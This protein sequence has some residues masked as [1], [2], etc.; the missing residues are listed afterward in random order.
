MTA[1]P[2][3]ATTTRKRRP[4]PGC[5]VRA[6]PSTCP[7][8]CPA[9]ALPRRLYGY[10]LTPR[11]CLAIPPGVQPSNTSH[12]CWI[13]NTTAQAWPA[14]LMSRKCTRL[15]SATIVPPVNPATAL[16]HFA[17][18]AGR[19]CTNVT[20]SIYDASGASLGTEVQ[21]VLGGYHTINHTTSGP[22]S[23]EVAG[24]VSVNNTGAVGNT[25]IV[26]GECTNLLVRVH[27][28]SVS[29]GAAVT[30]SVDDDGHN[31]PWS[32]TAS[33]AELLGGAFEYSSCM[34]DNNFTLT[35]Q[36]SSSDGWVGTV[37]V[38]EWVPDNTIYV[39]N[40]AK[41][42][43]QGA[44][45]LRRKADGSLE[46]GGYG[47]PVYFDNGDGSGARLS[48]GTPNA[49]SN[50]S[51]VLRHLR[52]AG[53]YGT[54]DIYPESRRF[55]QLPHSR[56]GCAIFYEGGRGST[57]VFETVVWDHNGAFSGS[58][59][60]LL[61][62]GRAEDDPD[63]V[64][65]TQ[66]CGMTVKFR[67]CLFWQ[68]S[69][70]IVG[71]IRAVNINPVTWLM[72]DTNFIDN[73]AQY[74]ADYGVGNYPNVQNKRGLFNQTALRMNHI[75][76]Q[77]RCL[78]EAVRNPFTGS[79]WCRYDAQA[80]HSQVSFCAP[81]QFG[82]QTSVEGET[83]TSIKLEDIVVKGWV[84]GY[85]PSIIVYAQASEK[86]VHV[87]MKNMTIV[88]NIGRRPVNIWQAANLIWMMAQSG[89]LHISN[90]R[91]SNN[92][93][94]KGTEA[95]TIAQGSG[96]LIQQ[97]LGHSIVIEH[98]EFV[99]GS[100]KDGGAVA[101]LDAPST[102]FIQCMFANNTAYGQGG[103]IYFKGLDFV[104]SRV[105]FSHNH[106]RAPVNKLV[107]IT[108]RVYTGGS[109]VGAENGYPLWKLDGATPATR[110]NCQLSTFTCR[111]PAAPCRD[112]RWATDAI[113]T[114]F[115]SNATA[116]T[117][118]LHKHTLYAEVMAVSPGV[119]RLWHGMQILIG[120]QLR[121]WTGGGWI[122]VVDIRDK[123]Y[124]TYYDNRATVDDTGYMRYDNYDPD[125][126]SGP[127]APRGACYAGDVKAGGAFTC[128][129][130]DW[131]WSYTDFVVPYGEGGAIATS[132]A[133]TV[134][135]VDSTFNS[136]TAGNGASV[137]VLGASRMD[138]VGSQ[139]LPLAGAKPTDI[140]TT[141]PKGTCNTSAATLCPMGQQCTSRDGSLHCES[142][143]NFN[144]FGNGKLCVQCDIGKGPNGN[145]TECV[146][147]ANNEMSPFGFCTLCPAGRVKAP[148]GTQC[149]QCLSGKIAKGSHCETCSPGSQPSADGATCESCTKFGGLKY[150]D[151]GL[152]CKTCPVGSM[153]NTNA[154]QCT[155]QPGR[156]DASTG[157]V[158]CVDTNWEEDLFSTSDKFSVAANQ[159]REFIAH[160]DSLMCINCP[161][162]LDCFYTDGTVD[163]SVKPGFSLS[164]MAHSALLAGASAHTDKTFLRC[165]PETG[166]WKERDLQEDLAT[167]VE[168]DI[169]DPSAPVVCLGGPLSHGLPCR[170][171]HDG[172]LCASCTEGYGRKLG[173]CVP[174]SDTVDSGQL[175]KAAF[176]GVF[177]SLLVGLALIGL[178]FAIGDVYETASVAGE[179]QEE[180]QAGDAKYDNPLNDE[181][182]AFSALDADSSGQLDRDEARRIFEKAAG[183][184]LTEDELT[185]AMDVDGTVDELN[186]FLRLKSE[187][188][189]ATRVVTKHAIMRSCK[190]LLKALV[191]IS[192]QPIKIFMS[193]FQIAGQLATVLHFHFPPMMSNLFAFFQ[194]L[195]A[196]VQGL[197][198]LECA[199]LRDYYKAWLFQVFFIPLALWGLVG[200]FFLYRHQCAVDTSK[201][202]GAMAKLKDETFLV[203]FLV[204]P[205][206][207]NRFFVLLNC[208]QLSTDE[209]VLV[210]DYSI[211]CTTNQHKGYQ[212]LAGFAIV[213]FSVGVPVSIAILMLRSKHQQNQQFRT[214]TWRYI[215]RK[216]MVQLGHND[217]REVKYAM[218]DTTLGNR[219]GTLVSTYHPGF[220][221]FE[222]IDM[223]R[224]LLLVGMLTVVPAGSTFQVATGMA[225]SF[226][227]FAAH[228]R[229]LPFRFLEDNVL[230]ATTE[231]HLFVV[232]VLVMTLKAR[233]DGEFVD[234][235]DYD[236]LCGVAFVLLVPV[237][238]VV[239]II[240]KWRT[241]VGDEAAALTLSK[242]AR[243]KMAFERQRRGRD[244]TDDRELL[245]GF[246]GELRDGVESQY[247]VFISYRVASEAKFAKALY[248]ALSQM[249]ITETGQKLRVYL[250]Q[251]RLEDGERWDN[252]FM[253]GLS[254]SWVAV[255][256]VSTQGLQPM[257]KLDPENQSCDNVLLE[258]MAALELHARG[259]IDAVLP[260]ITCDKDG[261]GFDWALP[262]QL[263]RDEHTATTAA[264]RS[265]S[266][267]AP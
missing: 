217:L 121:S 205:F 185:T 227:F 36:V 78:S 89:N 80:P 81:F 107:D 251:V 173:P 37:S 160:S 1:K 234:V 257:L 24:Y 142:T 134:T 220:F 99:G 116:A 128:P 162:C 86:D 140:K 152:Q 133:G 261:N 90:S 124:P 117:P 25:T 192:A 96:L 40:N 237:T 87:S 26:V 132:G 108:V 31:G 198:A 23:L 27:T 131:F 210:D 214:P 4:P 32:F 15:D 181:Q 156:Y 175:L 259:K 246:F 11:G 254:T 30:F 83:H 191:S 244:K 71:T 66:G 258:W 21:C 219:Y 123:V 109:G 48:S 47:V 230:K 77:D 187:I 265:Q 150:S 17:V 153:S 184:T 222:T 35:K 157:V 58:G 93:I 163:Y 195:V 154:T 223:L 161:D 125:G 169:E 56:L 2:S 64:N 91:M 29:A 242:T 70:F 5:T 183:R 151:D 155:C 144:E 10:A 216:A 143:C 130:G 104:L 55:S 253:Q 92:T 139:F 235:D 74:T 171:G 12:A 69:A 207:T 53:Q 137:F 120:G 51:I 41:W 19:M 68:N 72:Q 145:K 211:S 193:Y 208:R 49:I 238:A 103:A 209:T 63:P 250:D 44:T 59:A 97:W 177:V 129:S 202:A 229:C 200:T 105:L 42:I 85:H 190:R 136:N 196:N 174:C 199:G 148:S 252:G 114:V 94:M 46:A 159:L 233:P 168:V 179:T 98:T 236:T 141:R 149:D 146:S 111:A 240:F 60:A 39:P 28:T 228:V 170:S 113:D 22:H 158:T 231:A 88:D 52:L 243:L 106:V 221:F 61:I 167:H 84:V 73:D 166:D 95:G 127:L 188:V 178:S 115:G 18:G 9:P 82:G 43:I 3:S 62:S 138:I 260:I 79:Y 6:C 201:K 213:I 147:C 226:L 101:I 67:G 206:M 100:A 14:D 13:Y 8:T 256:I 263:R 203:L 267:L 164:P 38:V 172:T 75:R 126:L 119:H 135:I 76:D 165:Q 247:H 176:L 180:S 45:D 16:V 264:V 118:H 34:F 7:S 50:A 54:L 212:M 266:L 57:L 225:T 255:P 215:A 102:R 239:C 194:P 245:S 204:Y 248:D 262:K 218:I 110:C 182:D 241:V 65:C 197:V 189:T 122:D 20:I 224:K 33:S 186:R 232:L 112:G 249:V